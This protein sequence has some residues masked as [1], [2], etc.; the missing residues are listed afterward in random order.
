ME[1]WHL[2]SQSLLMRYLD[3]LKMLVEGSYGVRGGL[4]P[5]VSHVEK[6]GSW[7]LASPD[8]LRLA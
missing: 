5:H 3:R 4:R 2:S 6:S 7:A 8:A 1:I